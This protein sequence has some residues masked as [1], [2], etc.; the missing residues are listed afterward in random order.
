MGHDDKIVQIVLARVRTSTLEIPSRISRITMNGSQEDTNI[1]STSHVPQSAI[2]KLLLIVLSRSGSITATMANTDNN[3]VETTGPRETLSTVPRT[4][5][6][7]FATVL[8]LKKPFSR[9]NLFAQP[10][11]IEESY[12]I[13]WSEFKELLIKKYC[14]QDELRNKSSSGDYPRVLKEMVTHHSKPSK[15]G[16]SITIT[17]DEVNVSGGSTRPRNCRKKGHQLKQPAASVSNLSC[18]WRERT[19]QKSVP[20]SKQQCLWESILAEGQECSPRPER[21]HG[22]LE[23]SVQTKYLDKFVIVFMRMIFSS[24]PVTKRTRKLPENKYLELLKKENYMP[25]LHPNVISRS[26]HA[27]SELVSNNSLS[28]FPYIVQ[29]T[30][31]MILIL[32]C[33]V[34]VDRMAPKRTSTSA[35]LAMSQA[36]IRKVV[37]DSVAAALEA[38]AANMA[39]TNNTNRNTRPRETPV[40]RKCIYKEFMSCQPFNFKGTEGV[41]GLIYWFERT[42]SVFSHS[43]YTEDCKVKFATGTLTKEALS[44]SWQ[45]YVQ[46]W[47]QILR[48]LWKS[49][50][51]LPRSIEGHVTASKPQTLEEAITI[52]QRT[53]T[54]NNNHNND[55]HQQQNR[56]QETI[57]AY[58]ATP[59][60]NN[61]SLDQELQ[62][63]GASNWKQPAASVSNLSCF[64]H[65][66]IKTAPFEA[67]YGQKCRSLV[68]W[69]EVGDVQLT[70]PEIIYETTKKIVQI[71][72]CLQAA[73]DQQRSYANVRRKPLEEFQVGDRVMLKV[74]P[75]KGVIRFRKRG[76]LNPRYIGPFK[77]LKRVGL[78][79]Y[80]L[81]LPEELS[82]VH[83]TFHVSNLKKCLSDESCLIIPMK[84]LST[85]DKLNLVEATN[86]KLWIE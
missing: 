28:K 34:N 15:L 46:I 60:N 30:Y 80:T 61:R 86:K 63:Q 4:S 23:P 66:S 79:A 57:R 32:C 44:W 37:A 52:T 45:F 76:K 62:K 51:G 78:V 17:Q 24:T 20:K 84:E 16:G 75:R 14:A 22:P 19:L 41:V 33:L 69:A 42:E 11:G 82:N 18:L 64:Y 71:R 2:R 68:C 35:A 77:I 25:K 81:E 39:N 3:H 73:R 65:A 29:M 5:K 12:K 55:H 27:I 9:W 72:Q 13:T 47:C 49:S 26:Y 21:S 38:Q 56:R 8:L 48:N 70:G 50:S 83:S 85:G 10:I 31:D 67:L 54:N 74:P 7:K 53:F 1:C 36:A 40:A 43:N 6:V 58:A 59:T